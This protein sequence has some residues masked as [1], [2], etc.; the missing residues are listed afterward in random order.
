MTFFFWS[1]DK[2]IVEDRKAGMFPAPPHY[3]VD[4]LLVML[5]MPWNHMPLGA[6]SHWTHFDHPS[7]PSLMTLL[8]YMTQLI[9]QLHHIDWAPRSLWTPAPIWSWYLIPLAWWF[10]TLNTGMWIFVSDQTVSWSWGPS[11]QQ[12]LCCLCKQRDLYGT[13]VTYL[14]CAW[15]LRPVQLPVWAQCYVMQYL[16]CVCNAQA[17][18]WP[19][20]HLFE[21]SAMCNRLYEWNATCYVMQYVRCVCVMD[22]MMSTSV[23]LASCV[24]V[25]PSLC[26][27]L[28]ECNVWVRYLR[29][30]CDQ[31]DQH[32]T[33]VAPVASLWVRR[34]VQWP[35]SIE[36]MR[37]ARVSSLGYVCATNFLLVAISIYSRV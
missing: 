37:W 30:A 32:G 8:T 13:C 22:C 3:N 12:C 14:A 23:T 11:F 18:V 34:S 35:W 28:C 29:C 26:S 2:R 15:V 9:E 16:W 36:L 5:T 4:S 7:L 10:Q 24:T 25:K 20:W 33:C 21:S 31:R 27:F 1:G 19:I 17:P 6:I